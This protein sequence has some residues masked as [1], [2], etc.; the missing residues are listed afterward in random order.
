MAE[1]ITIESGH[2]VLAQYAESSCR[3]LYHLI[4]S[5]QCRHSIVRKLE[6][7]LQY[8]LG[9]LQFVNAAAVDPKLSEISATLFGCVQGL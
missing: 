8:L 7:E 1:S 3:S 5:F 4:A 6:Q 2:Q 9:A